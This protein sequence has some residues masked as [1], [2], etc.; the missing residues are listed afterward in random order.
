MTVALFFKERFALFHERIALSL[1]KN[2]RFTQKTE[3]QIPNPENLVSPFLLIRCPISTVNPPEACDIDVVKRFRWRGVKS[4]SSTSFLAHEKGGGGG[5]VD[6][7]WGW[8]AVRSSTTQ[9][10]VPK[11]NVRIRIEPVRSGADGTEY[12]WV[13]TH[14][15]NRQYLAGNLTYTFAFF[16]P[17]QARISCEDSDYFWDSALDI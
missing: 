2:E 6:D 3:E 11:K 15:L 12:C 8:F 5:G 17:W 9:Y 13:F 1:T 4:L 16:K 7:D 14:I 10:T